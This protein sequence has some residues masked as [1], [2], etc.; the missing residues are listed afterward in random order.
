[1]LAA[2][3]PKRK[4]RP[5]HPRDIDSDFDLLSN[6]LEV[7]KVASHTEM[8]VANSTARVLEDTVL[9]E[10]LERYGKPS[11][12][13]EVPGRTGDINVNLGEKK[14]KPSSKKLKS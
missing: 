14:K 11:A 8:N 10:I 1:M 6:L 4:P 3:V 7:G 9:L 5:S 2:K 13:T 12:N